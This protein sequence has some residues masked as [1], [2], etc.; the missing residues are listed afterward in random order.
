M[1]ESAVALDCN[2]LEYVK[3]QTNKIC[4]IA[5]ADDGLALKFV[6]NQTDMI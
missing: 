1:C 3:D 5:I 2:A 6:R 4:K